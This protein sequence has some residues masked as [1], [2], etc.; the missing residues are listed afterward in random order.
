MPLRAEVKDSTLTMEIGAATLKFA[1]ENGEG[2]NSYSDEVRDFR[3]K[4]SI[5]DAA[6]FAKD[7]CAAMNA[8]GEDGSTPLTRFLD[9][10]MSEAIE[11]G[12]LGIH[13]PD[14]DEPDAGMVAE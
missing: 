8:E 6:Q 7:I 3:R 13:D 1:F 5:S 14:G 9:Q 2:N 4:F 10:M 11:Q 12:S